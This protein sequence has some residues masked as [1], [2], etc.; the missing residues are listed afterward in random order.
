MLK[1]AL[2]LRFVLLKSCGP[3]NDIISF[4]GPLALGPSVRVCIILHFDERG[5]PCTSFENNGDEPTRN[6]FYLA[7]I[8][9]GSQRHGLILS[10]YVRRGRHEDLAMRDSNL[11]AGEESFRLLRIRSRRVHSRYS[12]YCDTWFFSHNRQRLCVRLQRCIC[13]N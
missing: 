1:R 5:F 13:D 9:S 8:K 6:V 11:D 2:G 4:F 3:P 7:D 12:R 10:L